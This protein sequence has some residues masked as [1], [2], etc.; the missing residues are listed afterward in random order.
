[1]KTLKIIGMLFLL[2][3]VQAAFSQQTV[4]TKKA[5]SKPFF[6]SVNPYVSISQRH[7]VFN[8]SGTLSNITN[9]QTVYDVGVSV[10]KGKWRFSGSYYLLREKGYIPE[11]NNFLRP[12]LWAYYTAA[13]FGNWT[14]TLSGA[15][16]PVHNEQDDFGALAAEL[17][18]L[19]PFSLA[20]GTLSFRWDN[21]VRVDV[22]HEKEYVSP[23]DQTMRTA[24]TPAYRFTSAVELAFNPKKV[25]DLLFYVGVYGERMFEE[26][27][28]Y[29]EESSTFD[30]TEKLSDRWN[31][32]YAKSGVS[33]DITD[34]LNI[35][36]QVRFFME[37]GFRGLAQGTLLQNRLYLTYSY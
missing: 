25:K 26:S 36:E 20:A 13:K 9:L 32:S 17:V 22:N 7:T 2:F 8:E 27:Y 34:H 5:A 11:T 19:K 23:D 15:Y 12:E 1:M 33:Y 14:T 6:D 18:Y 16:M 3:T 21:D 28:A 31:Y 24:D 4:S 35:N 37:D 30:K 29:D 10:S